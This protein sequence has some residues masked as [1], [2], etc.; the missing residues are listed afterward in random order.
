MAPTIAFLR[1]ASSS[2]SRNSGER[3]R[4]G[5]GAGPGPE[6]LRGEV[7][8]GDLAQVVVHVVGADVA[9]RAVLVDVLEQLLA[10]QLLALP[11]ERGQAAVA[12][13]DL[14]LLAALAAEAEADLAP[15]DRRRGGSRS[16]VRP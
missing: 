13:V 8:A 4:R 10:G 12:H 2:T 11:D 15:R 5:D 1:P 6:V 14:V 16:V 3:Q 9:P 7:V